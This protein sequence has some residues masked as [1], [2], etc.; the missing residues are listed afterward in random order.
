MEL[1]PLE[2]TLQGKIAVNKQINNPFASSIQQPDEGS[3]GSVINSF[4]SLLNTQ[5]NKL[6]ALQ[7]NAD[8]AVQ[9]YSVGGPIELH[10]VMIAVDRANTAMS[11]AVQVRNKLITAYQ[12][13]S[14][15]NV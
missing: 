3:A 13:I 15:M 4:G 14:R 9:T 2:A 5:I 7:S 10:N 11:F 1:N 8:D 6:N 12:E